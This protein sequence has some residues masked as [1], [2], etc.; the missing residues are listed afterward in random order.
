MPRLLHLLREWWSGIRE[1]IALV[2]FTHAVMTLSKLTEPKAKAWA[3]AVNQQTDAKFGDRANL[4]QR[5]VA[6]ILRVI[7]EGIS[8]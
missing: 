3:V 7:A 5:E 4:V 6:T 1:Q 8:A 2:A